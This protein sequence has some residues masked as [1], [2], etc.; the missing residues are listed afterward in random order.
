MPLHP[1]CDRRPDQTSNITKDILS[2]NPVNSLLNV[3]QDARPIEDYVEEFLDLSCGVPL[4]ERT[5]KTIFWGGLDDHLYQQ[6]PASDT[7]FSLERY[8]E[9][10]LWLSGS[11]FTVEEVTDCPLNP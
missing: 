6:M 2:L 7:I 3:F 10:A 4:K 9:Y 11:S 5:L 8:I 1:V